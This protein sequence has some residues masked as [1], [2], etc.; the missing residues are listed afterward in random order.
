MLV[1]MQRAF[2]TVLA[3]LAHEKQLTLR[4]KKRQ[5]A[6]NHEFKSLQERQEAFTESK[7]TELQSLDQGRIQH[8]EEVQALK[9]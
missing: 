6:C 2:K 5:E 8:Y 1:D 4:L 9:K 7:K 3:E